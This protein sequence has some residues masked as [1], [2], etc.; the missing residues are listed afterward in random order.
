MEKSLVILKP[1]ALHRQLFGNF[2]DFLKEKDLVIDEYRYI[3]SPTADKINQHYL[4][5]IDKDW[6]PQLFEYMVGGPLIVMSIKG[7][8]VSNIRLKC[9]TY[10][11]RHQ[12]GK[13]YNT[14]HASDS[15][16]SALRE[17]KVWGLYP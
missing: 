12:I 2:C 11:S 4:E 3:Q 14:I 17:L 6:Y 8:T 9:M 5:H 1:D 7:D 16:E 13:M 10:R 15:E